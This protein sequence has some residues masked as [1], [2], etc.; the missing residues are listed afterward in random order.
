MTNFGKRSRINFASGSVLL[1]VLTVSATFFFQLKASR[2][3]LP[4]PEASSQEDRAGKTAQLWQDPFA[5]IKS[6]AKADRLDL[7]PQCV[8]THRDNTQ[9]APLIG[10]IHGT[11]VISVLVPGEPRSQDAE[12]RRRTRFAVLAGLARKGFERAY[13]RG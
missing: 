11:L 9:G 13:Q 5:A 1:A 6:F 2:L 4:L 7:E 8:R 12:V 10:E 3:G